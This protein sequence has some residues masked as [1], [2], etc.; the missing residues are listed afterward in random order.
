MRTQFIVTIY[1]NYRDHYHGI[2]DVSH[3]T[4]I[5][6]Y[7]TRCAN[8]KLIRY[9]DLLKAF[10]RVVKSE[11]FS[12]KTYFTFYVHNMF[13]V[14]IFYKYHGY[15]SWTSFPYSTLFYDVSM[16]MLILLTFYRNNLKF[17]ATRASF[18]PYGLILIL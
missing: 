5:R 11:F 1:Y 8:M 17:N 10:D 16:L 18:T 4:Y 2:H 12:E 9:F 14:A 3:G 6:W 7:R 15:G 13:L